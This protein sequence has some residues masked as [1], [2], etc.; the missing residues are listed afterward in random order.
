MAFRLQYSFD[1][2]YKDMWP[3]SILKV[4][5]VKGCVVSCDAENTQIL[6]H[7]ASPAAFIKKYEYCRLVTH[8]RREGKGKAHGLPSGDPDARHTLMVSV[9][10]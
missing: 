10:G 6:V 4:N 9:L 2:L 8:P 5:S 7:C 3:R 1:M